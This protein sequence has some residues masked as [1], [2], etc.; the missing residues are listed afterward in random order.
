MV[1][2]IDEILLIPLEGFKALLIRAMIGLRDIDPW[3]EGALFQLLRPLLLVFLL[4][5]LSHSVISLLLIVHHSIGYLLILGSELPLIF[6]IP[7]WRLPGLNNMAVSD[8]VLLLGEHV[9]IDII[10][11]LVDALILVLVYVTLVI[12][13]LVRFTGLS[14]LVAWMWWLVLLRLLSLIPLTPILSI[15]VLVDIHWPLVVLDFLLEALSNSILLTLSLNI[16]I[17]A[18]Q[19]CVFLRP[20]SCWPLVVQRNADLIPLINQILIDL[21]SSGMRSLLEISWAHVHEV[22]GIPWT[23]HSRLLIPT[24]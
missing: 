18:S 14:R 3:A 6:L 7:P 16:F 15:L 13:H 4:L 10:E 8:L 11:V 24:L 5:E 17:L 19:P 22:L 1:L 2:F 9:G 23:K 12:V 21:F 20:V